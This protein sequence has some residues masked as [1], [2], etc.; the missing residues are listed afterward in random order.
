ML[1]WVLYPVILFMFS[2]RRSIGVDRI[3]V[4]VNFTIDFL[5]SIIISFFS[6]V[7]G[8]LYFIKFWLFMFLLN[9]FQA[10]FLSFFK[11]LRLSF[12]RGTNFGLKFDERWGIEW[13]AA[14]IIIV[15]IF[16]AS[17]FTSLSI[18]LLVFNWEQILL[19]FIQYD[20]CVLSVGLKNRSEWWLCIMGKW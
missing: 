10:V 5:F 15:R 6:S 3:I 9:K 7:L 1:K 11:L 18:G 8:F 17:L 20:C 13:F 12:H 19:N 16:A 4:D 2:H 14:C